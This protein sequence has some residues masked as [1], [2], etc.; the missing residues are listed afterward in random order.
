MEG[1]LIMRLLTIPIV[2]AALLPGLAPAAV[3]TG[4]P[5]ADEDLNYSV[6]WPSGLSLGE[7]HLHSKHTGANWNFEFD[8]DAGVPGYQV[9]DIYRS[10]STPAFC[11][12][13]FSRHTSHGGH[14]AD[15]LETVNGSQATRETS[16]GGGT[17]Q[18]AVPD[19]VKD[20]LTFLFFARREL[21]QG[22][23]PNA[24]QMLLGGLYQ[25]R[26]DYAGEQ[27]IPV[28]EL[29]TISDKITCTVKGP[30]ST[31]TFEMYFA[32]DPART[33]LLFKAPLAMGMFSMELTR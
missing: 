10:E 4:F 6:N 11:S 19:C 26:L 16:N 20:A 8:I 15:E 13:S 29:P 1:K 18:L 27:T 23:V 31:V 28:G 5:F 17:S 3:M 7:A 32:R 25:A 12:V 21:G 2:A 30:T 22:R 24:Q 9:K 14:K 33:P